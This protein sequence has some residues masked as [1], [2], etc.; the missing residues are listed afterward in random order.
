MEF[1]MKAAVCN[2]RSGYLRASPG[3]GKMCQEVR[4]RDTKKG[5][6]RL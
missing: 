5:G 2:R 4:P 3:N 1:F 6:A